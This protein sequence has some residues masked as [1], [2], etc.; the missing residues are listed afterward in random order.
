[1]IQKVFAKPSWSEA[2]IILVTRQSS[3]GKPQEAYH[4]WYNRYSIL[5]WPGGY[6]ILTWLRAGGTP[7]W[8]TLWPGL[9]TL[10]NLGLRYPRKGGYIPSQDWGTSKKGSGTSH[11]GTS[12]SRR[13]M[14]PVEVWDGDGVPLERTWDQWKYGMEMGYPPSAGGWQTE[15]ITSGRTSY[16]DGNNN[17]WPKLLTY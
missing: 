11:W 3:C 4:L 10:S 5:T 12:S 2:K 7:L 17:H 13:D 16:S 15:N 14:R 9:E 8:S 6:P 1:M